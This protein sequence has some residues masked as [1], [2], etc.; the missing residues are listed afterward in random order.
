MVGNLI[1]A[2]IARISAEIISTP[3]RRHVELVSLPTQK[4]IKPLA[5]TSPFKNTIFHIIKS[6]FTTRL[7]NFMHLVAGRRDTCTIFSA[8]EIS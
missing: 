2:T 6:R 1:F 3:T 5:E 8:L 4:Y 7:A